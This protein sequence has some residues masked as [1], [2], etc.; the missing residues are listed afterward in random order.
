MTLRST[1]SFVFLISL[2]SFIHG[3]TPIKYVN[4]FIGTSNY[5]A[6]HPG[7]VRPAGMVSVVPFNSAFKKGQG[8]KFEKDSEW[9]SRPYVYENT[10]FTGF[11]HVNLSGVGCPDLGSIIVMPTSGHLHF[12]PETN[13]STVS[14]QKASPGQYS[15]DIDKHN[16]QVTTTASSF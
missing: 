16:I 15:C 9:H 4:P 2:S 1:L 6:T 11:S 3:Q 7:P 12:S 14:N 10:F 13:G 8:N 5:G